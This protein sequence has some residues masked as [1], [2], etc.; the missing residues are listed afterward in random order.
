MH[1]ETDVTDRQSIRAGIGAV[2]ALGVG[3]VSL[4][5]AWMLWLVVFFAP[6]V[7]GPGKF[8]LPSDLPGQ[9]AYIAACAACLTGFLLALLTFVGH[10]RTR[11]ALGAWL[12]SFMVLGAGSLASHSTRADWPWVV[13]AGVVISTVASGVLLATRDLQSNGR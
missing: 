3:A 2:S 8:T 5:L 10:A 11:L 9:A 12:G 6:G 7:F 4:L 13:G 1:R